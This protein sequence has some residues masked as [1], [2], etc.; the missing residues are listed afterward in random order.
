MSFLGRLKSHFLP[1]KENA[2][3]PHAL[4]GR[5]L[6][7]FLAISLAAEGFLVASLVSRHSGYE[8]ISAVIASDIVSL[9]N[10]QR[11]EASLGTLVENPLLVEAA[12]RKAKDMA[13]RGYF[14]HNGPDGKTPWKWLSESGYNYRYAGENLA[15]RFTDS[16]DVVKAWMGSP[17]HKANVVKGVYSEIGVGVASGVYK[18]SPAVYV[19]Q[20]FGTSA[21]TAASVANVQ[22]PSGVQAALNQ[23][24]RLLAE[25]RGATSWILSSVASLLI[26]LMGL[27][28][29]VHSRVQVTERLMPGAVVAT[30]ALALLVLN[31]S[32]LTPSDTQTAAVGLSGGA[33]EVVIGEDGAV[34]P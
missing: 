2:Y 19:V 17:S 13:A 20:F 12:N 34:A 21:G 30:V 7:F 32:L 28:I 3:R 18:G 25:P 31:T 6:V 27:A 22:P 24:A 4:G 11:A 14:S 5:W 29:A 8:F 15:V 33:S 16:S 23:I 10:T 26:V 1:T 9:T